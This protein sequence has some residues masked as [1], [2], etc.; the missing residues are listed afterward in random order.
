VLNSNDGAGLIRHIKGTL[1]Q[2]LKNCPVTDRN[3]EELLTIVFSM[4]EFTREEIQEVQDYRQLKGGNNK[5]QVRGNSVSSSGGG[6]I[7]TDPNEEELKKRTSK[8]LFGMFRKGSRDKRGGKDEDSN[9]SQSGY[10]PTKGVMTPAP[11]GR[12]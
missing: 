12:R 6:G 2:F 4:M 9:S 7:G 5:G 8:G 11:I 3:N 10:T 1:L